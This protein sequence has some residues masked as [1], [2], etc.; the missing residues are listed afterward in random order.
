MAQPS[1]LHTSTVSYRKLMKKTKGLI[2]DKT[3]FAIAEHAEKPPKEQSKKKHRFGI[4]KRRGKRDK[5]GS[6]GSGGTASVT[7]SISTSRRS[8]ASANGSSLL[9][10]HAIEWKE[11]RYERR[12]QCLDP[13]ALTLGLDKESIAY[14][15]FTHKE[16]VRDWAKSFVQLDPRHQILNF[17][18]DVAQEGT[19]AIELTGELRPELFSP[20]RRFFQRSSVFSVWRPTSLEAIQKMMLGV[21]TGKGLDIKGKS[22]KKG[23]LSSYVPFLQIHEEEHKQLVQPMMKESRIRVFYKKRQ[24]RDTAYARLLECEQDMMGAGERDE[25]AESE[26]T[27]ELLDHCEPRCFGLSIPEDIFWESYVVRNDI[28]RPSG[29]EY[30]TGRNSLYSFQNMNIDAIRNG[31]ASVFSSTK[32]DGVERIEDHPPLPVLWQYTDPYSP[33]DKPDPDPMLPQTLLMAYEEEGGVKPVVSDFDC[34]LF[35]TR[36]VSYHEPLPKEQVDTMHWLV[37]EIEKILESEKEKASWTE[38]WLRVLRE[39]A[40]NDASQS[41]HNLAQE[42]QDEQY[43]VPRYGYGDPKSY[44]IIKCAV[45]RLRENGAVRHGAECFNYHFPQELDEK[46]LVI[47]DSFDLVP[48]RYVNVKELRAI[49]SQKI[50]EGYTFPLNPKWILCDDGWKALYDKLMKSKA[51][52]VQ[53]SLECWFPKESGIRERFEGISSSHPEGFCLKGKVCI[54]PKPQ[55]GRQFGLKMSSRSAL[56]L[57]R[58]FPSM[59]WSSSGSETVE[60]VEQK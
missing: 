36:G 44:S 3:M 10:F 23:K 46:F 33:P 6:T 56:D 43:I 26:T 2:S 31:H 11:K 27:I 49:L 22:A 19:D 50:D 35:G 58:L 41:S 4:S 14:L 5:H 47:S 34:F 38:R 12:R 29:S 42:E 18:R 53:E 21:G 28:S 60:V 37:S 1:T 24:A 32:K 7:S 8:T 39:E 59:L 45:K 51:S 20:L 25:E 40:G 52:Y 17:F 54:K 9:N 16:R 55:I 48:Y 13:S 57:R 15:D 30:E